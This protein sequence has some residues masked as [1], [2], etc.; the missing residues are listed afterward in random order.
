MEFCWVSLLCWILSFLESMLPLQCPARLKS[1]KNTWMNGWQ[2]TRNVNLILRSGKSKARKP[3]L[4]VCKAGVSG[5]RNQQ[6][7]QDLWGLNSDAQGWLQIC[8]RSSY[9]PTSS[10]CEPQPISPPPH[11]SPTFPGRWQLG[12][13]HTTPHS[14]G[15]RK[16]P[17][18]G[19]W[20]A[21]DKELL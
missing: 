1:L 19:T 10:C 18:W 16:T 6:Q 14:P 15:R 17:L 11:H 13:D 2:Q 8:R 21:Q 12:M 5:L 9:A 3:K 20:Q 7:H 4:P